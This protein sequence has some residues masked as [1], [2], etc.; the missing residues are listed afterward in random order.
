MAIDETSKL[1]GA[2]VTNVDRLRDDMKTDREGASRHRQVLR[3][4]IA[5]IKQALVRG[6]GR[7][8]AIEGRFDDLEPRVETHLKEC[9]IKNERKIGAALYRGS[10]WTLIGMPIGAVVTW[11]AG[12][13][14][15]TVKVALLA[16]GGH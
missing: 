4:D 7:M 9:L 8:A 2:L 5:E 10:I 16:A 13:V 15:N 1:L 11:A 14:L 3:D 6:D 12:Y